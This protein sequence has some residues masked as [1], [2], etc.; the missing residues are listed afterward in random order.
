MTAGA[1]ARIAFGLRA[2]SQSIAWIGIEAG[3][4][5]KHGIDMSIQEFE[6]GGPAV[7]VG[8]DRG[9]WEFGSTGST[10]V[11]ESFLTGGD[12][13]ILLQNSSPHVGVYVMTQPGISRLDQ[14]AGKNVGVLTDAYSG[15]TGAI[16]RMAVEKSGA[17]A[18]YVGLGS[19]PNI[20]AALRRGEIEAGALPVDYRFLG[21]D[22]FGWNSFE[23]KGLGVPSV[24][25]TTRK[26]IASNRD[27]AVSAVRAF[28]EAIHLFK[29]RP[30]V[31]VP[32]L[33][34]LLEFDDRGAVEK[35]HAFYVPLFLPVPRWSTSDGLAAVRNLFADRYPAARELRESD[36]CDPSVIDEVEQSGFVQ[37]LYGGDP[38]R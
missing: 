21:Q 29:T 16:T 12:T 18:T 32:L 13:V 38:G 31:V 28:V 25:A 17:M 8:L 27:F 5:R 33:Q 22:R 4:F 20:F 19:Y 14:L 26:L 15:Q 6:T 23:T 34:K 37:A 36:I 2:T 9:D 24:F 3:L 35:L 30:D 7:A 10:P 11:A 1:K